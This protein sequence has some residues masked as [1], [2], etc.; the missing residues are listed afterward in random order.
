MGGLAVPAANV[1][2]S[3]ALWGRRGPGSAGVV[4]REP[5]PSTERGSP[6]TGVTYSGLVNPTPNASPQPTWTQL[7]HELRGEHDDLVSAF[8]RE[9]SRDIDYGE[10]AVDTTDLR[11]TAELTME[12]YYSMLAG[13]PLTAEMREH[14]KLIGARRARQGV[15]LDELQR[16]TRISFRVIWRKLERIAGPSGAA[17]LVQSMDRILGAVESY[18]SDVQHAFAVEES[19][20]R[21]DSR[22]L[23]SRLISRLFHTDANLDT[24][25]QAIAGALGL[26]AEGPYELLA[27][28]GEGISATARS[29]VAAD[30][31]YMHES[32]DLLFLFR[33]E[34]PGRSWADEEPHLHGAHITGVR[35]LAQIPR[36]ADAARTLTCPSTTPRLATVE[37]D[38][39]AVARTELERALPSFS[40][41]VLAPLTQCTDHERTRLLETVIAFATSGSIKDAADA[42]Y[43]HRNTVVNRL[44]TFASITGYSMTVPAQAARVIVS[45]GLPVPQAVSGIT[46]R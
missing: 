8:L 30:D 45:L 4:G 7:I 31:V 15:Q 12:M 28:A 34:R 6:Q 25:V 1:F 14:P 10:T 19:R 20:L 44:H 27:V 32:P 22:M 13:D 21:R 26:P 23:R 42:L 24:R 43:C 17:V 35:G 39:P 18:L 41:A 9:F 5:P 29:Y 40:G 16:A 37:E 46:P 38:W 2:R 33:E 36:A 3:A 11:D